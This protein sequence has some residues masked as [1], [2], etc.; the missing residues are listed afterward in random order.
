M[1]IAFSETLVLAN[2]APYVQEKGVS[3]EQVFSEIEKMPAKSKARK[4]FFKESER[5][6]GLTEQQLKEMIKTGKVRSEACG[7]NCK[8][9]TAGLQ[10]GESLYWRIVKETEQVVY[11][12]VKEQWK[13]WFLVKCG[14]PVKDP[15]PPPLPPVTT[16]Q[17]KDCC[18]Q[19][20]APIVLES[21][22][23]GGGTVSFNDH[24]AIGTPQAPRFVS[25]FYP[26]ACSG[27]QFNAK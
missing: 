12:F 19:T 21:A 27:E 10:D 16:Y 7:E 24:L 2:P 5:N 25:V 3:F 1:Q 8:L 14:N 22:F 15:Q 11:V 18:W 9:E 23:I 26:I 4:E 20:G 6:L 17:K 13:P